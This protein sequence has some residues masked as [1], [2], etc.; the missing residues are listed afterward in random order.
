MLGLIRAEKHYAEAAILRTPLRSQ[1][2]L[3]TPQAFT[4]LEYIYQYLHY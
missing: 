4:Y 1:K 3:R 2:L